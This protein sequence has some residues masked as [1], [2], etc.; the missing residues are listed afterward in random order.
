MR[1]HVCQPNIIV[2]EEDQVF[3][4]CCSEARC[5]GVARRCLKAN[6][7]EF[8]GYGRSFG[9]KTVIA[10][11]NLQGQIPA[12][13]RANASEGFTQ[14]RWTV[15][16]WTITETFLPAVIGTTQER[17]K[18]PISVKAGYKCARDRRA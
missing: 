15:A 3:T 14:K 5:T 7:T 6:R 13:E 17:R 18:N 12:L 8:F 4:G 1:A 9:T 11:Q 16:G 2:V 10:N